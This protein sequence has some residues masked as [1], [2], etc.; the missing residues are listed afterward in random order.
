MI[1]DYWNILLTGLLLL[2]KSAFEQAPSGPLWQ[3]PARG[4]AAGALSAA[5][6]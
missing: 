3:G 6:R 1:G 5:P 4:G 2:K